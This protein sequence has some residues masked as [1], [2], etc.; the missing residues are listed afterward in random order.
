MTVLIS[1]HIERESNGRCSFG[2]IESLTFDRQPVPMTLPYGRCHKE[3]TCSSKNSNV[4]HLGE[5]YIQL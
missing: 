4:K 1:L 3:S 5:S 2:F